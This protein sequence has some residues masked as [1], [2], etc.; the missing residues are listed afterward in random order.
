MPVVRLGMPFLDAIE[1]ADALEDLT[2]ACV[3]GAASEAL[4]PL[5]AMQLSIR[6]VCM[7]YGRQQVPVEGAALHWLWW[8]SQR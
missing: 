6:A 5:K 3:G 2:D 4:L 8:P 1:L 7:R